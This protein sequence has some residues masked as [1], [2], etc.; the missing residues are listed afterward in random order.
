MDKTVWIA[1]SE[2]WPK[3]IL[4][5]A[6]G[7]HRHETHHLDTTG[8]HQIIGAGYHALR[9]KIH[10]LLGRAAFAIQRYGGEGVG[11]ARPPRD[12]PVPIIRGAPPAEQRRRGV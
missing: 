5:E 9:G 4:A 10:R 6:V 8:D 1:L 2:Q 3:I 11:E 7:A 12:G